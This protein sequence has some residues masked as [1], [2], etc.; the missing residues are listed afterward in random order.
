MATTNLLVAADP[1]RLQS[2]TD[3]ILRAPGLDP[4]IDRKGQ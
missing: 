1:K 4:Q 2:V 3:Q